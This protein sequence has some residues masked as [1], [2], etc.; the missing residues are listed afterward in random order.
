MKTLN[1]EG[2]NTTF[3][4]VRKLRLIDVQLKNLHYKNALEIS[5]IARYLKTKGTHNL[6]IHPEY[7]L[8]FFFLLWQPTPTLIV[9]YLLNTSNL[10]KYK[11]Y[12]RLY[13]PGV[14]VKANY[15]LG[16]QLFRYA[17]SYAL[18][19]KLGVPLYIQ[20]APVSSST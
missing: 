18:A 4:N 11:V 17:C 20:P 10:G 1:R 9:S 16:N 2:D 15:G 19:R 6:T 3:P 7:T 14:F 12:P 8:L 13:P 5:K